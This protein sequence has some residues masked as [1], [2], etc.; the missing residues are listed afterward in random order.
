MS[1]I[2]LTSIKNRIRP[3][4]HGRIVLSLAETNAPITA[5]QL[6]LRAGMDW[7]R[8]PVSAFAALC[9]RLPQI[10]A[11]LENIGWQVVRTGGTPDD[12]W[13]LAAIEKA[14]PDAATSEAASTRHDGRG[15][16]A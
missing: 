14:A 16:G 8:N 12:H 6:M 1:A 11:V 5:K 3:N 2:P 4:K 9:S 15:P 10:N 13:Y 7:H